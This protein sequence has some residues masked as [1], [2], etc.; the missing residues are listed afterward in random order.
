MRKFNIP[1]FAFLVILN[2]PTIGHCQLVNAEKFRIRT[3][4]NGWFGEIGINGSY[5]QSTSKVIQAEGNLLTEYKH[6]KHL[7]IAAAYYG[8]LK[9]DEVQLVDEAM[10]H[11]RYN[12]KCNKYLRWEAFVQFQQ[13]EILNLKSR[14]LLGTGPRFKLVDNKKIR[15]YVASLM[16]Y[17]HEEE[18]SQNQITHEN[19]RSS[20]YLSFSLFPYE[21][22]EFITTTY[23]QPLVNEF[24]DY[25]I[26]NQS[27]LKYGINKHFYISINYNHFYDR[28]PPNETL[29]QTS[30]VPTGISYQI[31]V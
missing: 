15:M 28:R 11:L 26:L 3:D 19:F 8:F 20:S 21:R 23:F 9:G 7:F 1:T 12:I 14:F 25:R 24:Y 27:T 4:S 5:I 17:E 6:N 31:K 30:K 18:V 13:N 16:M 22:T 29:K 10:L 2:L